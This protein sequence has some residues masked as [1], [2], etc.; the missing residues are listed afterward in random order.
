[1]KKILNEKAKETS[2]KI[3][4]SLGLLEALDELAHG[5]IRMTTIISV[6]KTT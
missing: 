2:I 6:I 3:L 1:M 5:G 4:E